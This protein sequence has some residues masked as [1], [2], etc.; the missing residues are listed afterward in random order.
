MSKNITATGSY[1]APN[2]ADVS[3]EFTYTAFDS[4]QDAIAVLGE[5]N[6]LKCVQRMVKIDANNSTR[7]SV[8]AENGHS[9]RKPMTEEQKAQA[10]Q[11]RQADKELLAILK[12]KGLSVADLKNL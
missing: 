7:E 12:E 5:S 6:V 4:L 2:G 11:Q 9:A 10:K 8:K 1:T 3:Y